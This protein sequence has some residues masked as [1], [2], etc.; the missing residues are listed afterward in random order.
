MSLWQN[1]DLVGLLPV[2]AHCAE[3]MSFGCQH[4]RLC[5]N[6]EYIVVISACIRTALSLFHIASAKSKVHPSG[7]A[8]SH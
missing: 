2:A 1:C 7:V 8:I 5:L 6:R 4:R 3:Y